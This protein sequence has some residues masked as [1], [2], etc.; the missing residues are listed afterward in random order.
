MVLSNLRSSLDDLKDDLSE[1]CDFVYH[2]LGIADFILPTIYR[3]VF[4]RVLC[5]KNHTG[6]GG[7]D[8]NRYI[9]SFNG[10]GKYFKTGEINSLLAVQLQSESNKWS[11]YQFFN[12]RE[13]GPDFRFSTCQPLVLDIDLDYF[14][15]DNS[16]SQ[17]E[18][19]IE[20]TEYAY[21]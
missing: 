11:G 1:V 10:E 7:K 5:F 21:R 12:Y 20:I 15:C 14:S 2:E 17:V 16:L 4:N 3:G 8:T 6:T 13:I 19:K 18:K 9:A